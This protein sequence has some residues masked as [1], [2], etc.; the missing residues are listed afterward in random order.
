[1]FNTQLTPP[2]VPPFVAHV[3]AVAVATPE[4]QLTVPVTAA[5]VHPAV[6]APALH[7]A[8]VDQ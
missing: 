4:K 8:T 7:A 3:G 1:L 6:A 5:A 2:K